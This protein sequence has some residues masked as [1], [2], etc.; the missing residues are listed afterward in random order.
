MGASQFS[1]RPDVNDSNSIFEKEIAMKEKGSVFS[2]AKNRRSFLKNGIVAA[3]A[4]TIGTAMLPGTPAAFAAE[5]DDRSPITKGDIAI[6]T[7][8]QALEQ[9]EADLWIQYSELGGT[10][11]NEVSGGNGGNPAYTAA[12]TILDGDM[13]QYIHDNTDDDITHPTSLSI[14]L[15]SRA[16]YSP[17]PPPSRIS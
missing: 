13:P 7:F 15:Q 3:G 17:T 11:D 8:L 5:E 9:V 12:L 10:Q 16:P 6:L 2:R 4:A 14:F 1:E